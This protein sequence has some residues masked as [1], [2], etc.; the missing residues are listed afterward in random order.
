MQIRSSSRSEIQWTVTSVPIY[1]DAYVTAPQPRFPVGEVS[2][3]AFDPDNEQPIEGVFLA[4]W[5][6]QAS[7]GLVGVARR[8]GERA[9]E[10]VLAYLQTQAP[11]RD[12]ENVIDKFEQRL[13]ETH[14]RV[15]DKTHLT[16]LGIVRAG[17]SSKTWCSGI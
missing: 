12:L 6:R 11:M 17:R 16:K 5:A 8:D 3:E 2:Y 4:G 15:V 7:V 9:A 1:N 10:A 13:E 14:E